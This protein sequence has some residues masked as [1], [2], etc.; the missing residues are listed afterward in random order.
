MKING[1]DEVKKLTIM[2]AVAICIGL[3]IVATFE[4]LR[5]T[6]PIIK[7]V[8]V[9]VEKPV[10]KLVPIR[11]I[12]NFIF[13]GYNNVAVNSDYLFEHGQFTNCYFGFVGSSVAASI[14]LSDCTVNNS[15]LALSEMAVMHLENCTII[16]S[17]LNGFGERTYSTL[18][19]EHGNTFEGKVKI[20]INGSVHISEN[21][22]NIGLENIEFV[23]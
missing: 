6:N 13:M 20:Q 8:E 16:N 19:I 2:V 10:E 9:E 22:T 5:Y 1:G 3:G 18:Y 12:D 11:S 14:I 21:V 17:S 4:V 7:T 23:H 15:T